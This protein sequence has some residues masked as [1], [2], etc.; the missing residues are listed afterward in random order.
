MHGLDGRKVLVYDAA[1]VAAA[2]LDIP[3]HTAENTLIR[4]C[5]NIDLDIKKFS[6]SRILQYK[7][8]FHDNNAARLDDFDLIRTV[9]DRVIVDRAADGLP[10]LER[11]QMLDQKICLKRLGMIIIRLLP[12]L[13][14]NRILPFL[15]IVVIDDGDLVSE[16]V[17]QT[18]CKC[19]FSRAGSTG[20]SDDRRF[21][22]FS[23][24]ALRF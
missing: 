20:D 19:R 3:E 12:L 24:Q 8:P 5:L 15:I 6:D 13:K 17:L 1:Q 2:L 9:V 7:N 22:K 23:L 11:S 10:S 4:V 14:R 16:R 18:V 21:Q